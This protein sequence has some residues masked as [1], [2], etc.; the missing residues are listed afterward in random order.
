MKKSYCGK[1]NIKKRQRRRKKNQRIKHLESAIVTKICRM[2][3][4][5]WGL[6]K[7]MCLF[8]ATIFILLTISR[9]FS[10]SLLFF[11]YM[12]ISQRSIKHNVYIGASYDIWFPCSVHTILMVWSFIYVFS[13]LYSTFGHISV[14]CIVCNVFGCVYGQARNLTTAATIAILMDRQR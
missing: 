2:L 9:S 11:K 8:S 5:V 7:G 13:R 6:F 14:I 3:F 1:A 4:K 12:T 10:L